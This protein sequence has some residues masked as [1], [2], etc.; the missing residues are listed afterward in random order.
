MAKKP[1]SKTAPSLLSVERKINV[2]DAIFF[3]GKWEERVHPEKFRPVRIVEKS[4]LGTISN[5]VKENSKLNI[6]SP[7]LQTV[8]S[9]A[10]PAQADTLLVSFSMRI[11]PGIGETSSCNDRSYAEGLKSIVQSYIQTHSLEVITSRYAENIANGRFLWRNRVGAQN[12]SI[13][14]TSK[15][16]DIVAA[17]LTFSA[18]SYSLNKFGSAEKG[19]GGGLPE[20]CATLAD[21]I[22]DGFSDPFGCLL[23]I[24][25]FVQLGTSQ[26]VYPSQEL[27]LKKDSAKKSKILY[28]VEY[29]GGKV[30]AFHSQK[31]G[32][33][34]RT[35][36]TWYP[37]DLSPATPIPVETYGTV[38]SEGVA[39][40]DVKSG[41]D[42]YTLLDK[43]VLDGETPEVDDQH[44]VIAMLI[45]G[46]VFSRGG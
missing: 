29:D 15:R 30:A 4:V 22:A 13:M 24:R 23:E 8:D 32:N 2:S 16:G 18:R 11:L 31:I 46:G 27:N 7:N 28:S 42:F 12:I 43:W 44:Y 39:H 21:A 26:E 25:A 5:R 34:I 45:R 37:H 3:A 17:P 40:R 9:A 1:A 33:A 38:T 41:R 19:G 35:M 36:D 14:V 10:L 6:E 20:S